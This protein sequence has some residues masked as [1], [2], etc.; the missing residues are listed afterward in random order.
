MA[1]RHEDFFFAMDTYREYKYLNELWQVWEWVIFGAEFSV[2]PT[3]VWIKLTIKWPQKPDFF[4]DLSWLL[5]KL[6]ETGFI[7]TYAWA[8][9]L[10]EVMVKITLKL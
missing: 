4:V 5:A 10:S 8:M 9:K 3:E 6:V 2:Y 7:A 1:Y